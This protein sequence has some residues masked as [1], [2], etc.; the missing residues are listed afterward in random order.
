MLYH[1]F[2]IFCAFLPFQFAL[3]PTSEI[4]LAIARVIIPVLFLAVLFFVL[5]NKSWPVFKNKITYFLLAFL[6]LAVFSIFFSNNLSWSIRKLLFLL[7]IAPIY[8]IA[9]YLLDTKRKQ[10]AAI[11]FLILGASLA[12]FLGIFQFLAQF[13]FGI[14]PVYAFL[15]KNIIPFFLGNSFSKAVLAYPSW[16]VAS[17]GATYMRAL[18]VFPDP[19]MFSYYLGMLIPWSIALWAT[20]SPPHQQFYINNNSS[21]KIFCWCGGMQRKVFFTFS[22]LLIAAD[23]FTFTRGSYV[24]LIASSLMILPLVSKKIAKKLVIGIAVFLLLLIVAP[25]NAVSGR[26]ISSFDVQ[27]GSNKERVANW[28]QALTIIVKNPFGVGIGSYSLAVDPATTYREPI[29]AHNLYLDIA[30]ELGIVSVLFFVA[31]LYFAFRN[32]WTLAK[33]EPFFI[34]GVASL[35]IFAV[36]SLVETPLYSVHVFAL[37]LIMLAISNSPK[38]HAL[39]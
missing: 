26:L 25:H 16:L 19:H 12:A 21:F 30:A 38:Q 5:K 27:E 13:I 8:F 24:A 39:K 33:K 6:T 2:L 20:S 17:E 37:F 22:A 14:D 3:N 18:S 36:H 34:A 28:K 35:T 23:V 9:I 4:D 10:R 11:A 1:F 7:S 29:Y 31:I 15:A 32:F